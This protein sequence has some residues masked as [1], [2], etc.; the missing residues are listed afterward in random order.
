MTM[1]RQKSSMGGGGGC[2]GGLGAESTA[3]EHFVLF[4]KNNLILGLF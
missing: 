3:L 2:N 4:G 1:P